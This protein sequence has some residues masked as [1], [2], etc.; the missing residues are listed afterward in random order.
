MSQQIIHAYRRLLRT[1]LQAIRY[2]KPARFTLQ[3]HLRDS[4]RNPKAAFNDQEIT[5]TLEFLSN[6][7]KY[8]GVEEKVV[9]NLIHVWGCKDRDI[10]ATLWRLMGEYRKR[11]RKDMGFRDAAYEKVDDDVRM[12]ECS[13]GIRLG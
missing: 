7:A 11:A 9:R 12:L 8:K 4:F 3:S 13:L 5:Q 2:A 1:S 6:A 10:P